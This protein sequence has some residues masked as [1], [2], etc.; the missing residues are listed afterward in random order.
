MPL[1]RGLIHVYTGN[2]KGKTSAAL[3][4]CLRAVGRG[5]KC[6]FVQF[7]KGVPTGE[8][9]AAERLDKFEFIQVGRR[10]YDFTVTPEDVEMAR[11]G[12]DLAREKAQTVDVLVLDELNV[13]VHLNL[14]KVEDVLNFLKEKPECLEVVITGRYARPEIIELADYVTEMVLIKHPFYKGVSAREGIDF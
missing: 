7:I 1:E 2:G 8:M 14:L 6:C 3:G 5:L 9:V 10:N 4:L 13:A 12:M 11:K